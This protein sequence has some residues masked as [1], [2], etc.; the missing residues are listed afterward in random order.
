MIGLLVSCVLCAPESVRDRLARLKAE[1]EFAK[2][3]NETK[4]G[5]K[6]VSITPSD[7]DVGRSVI[8]KIQ[9]EPAKSDFCTVR[10][11]DSLV[12]GFVDKS[13]VV[14]VRAPALKSGIYLVSVSY[15]RQMW[16]NEKVVIFRPPIESDLWILVFP[17]VVTLLLVGTIL[18]CGMFGVCSSNRRRVPRALERAKAPGPFD[19]VRNR[20]P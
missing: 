20:L 14:S 4:N 19:G 11:G 8:V 17:V 5:Y 15:D 10:F 13:G 18:W 12:K 6:I 2:R 1:S 16:S 3:A 7:I 9:I